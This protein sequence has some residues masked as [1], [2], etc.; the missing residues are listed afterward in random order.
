[1]ATTQVRNLP[2]EAV[3]TIELRA[4]NLSESPQK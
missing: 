1:M 4:E 2:G 3:R